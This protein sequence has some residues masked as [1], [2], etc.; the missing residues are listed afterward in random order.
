[1]LKFGFIAG[2]LLGALVVTLLREPKPDE[3]LAAMGPEPEDLLGKVK[4]RLREAQIAAN[5]ERKAR[6]AEVYQEYEE[7]LHKDESEVAAKGAEVKQKS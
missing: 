5:E 1:V 7:T 4:H 3:R 2:A 6:E